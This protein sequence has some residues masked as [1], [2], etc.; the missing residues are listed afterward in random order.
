LVLSEKIFT[1]TNLKFNLK[2]T[3][4]R[5]ELLLPVALLAT[6]GVAAQAPVKDNL[7]L[8]AP[9]KGVIDVETVPYGSFGSKVFTGVTLGNAANAYSVAFGPAS[10]AWS[11]PTANAIL[12]THRA[13]PAI[14]PAAVNSGGVVLDF[15]TD[16]GTTWSVNQGPVHIPDGTTRF[17]G[18]YP[19]GVIFNPTGNTVGA[20]AYSATVAPTLSASNGSWGGT[21]LA[22]AKLNS[23]SMSVVSD[24]IQSFSIDSSFR[25]FRAGD[26]TFASGPQKVLA[27]HEYYDF[28]AT[29]PYNDTMWLA[30]GTWDA[31]NQ[32]VAYTW[33][34]VHFPVGLNPSSGV[35][36]IGT[37]GIAAN[38]NTVWIS[39]IGYNQTTTQCYSPMFAKS[40]DGGATFGSV[41]NVNLNTLTSPEVGGGTLLSY[42]QTIYSDWII[43]DLSTGFSQDLVVDKNGNPH[44]IVNICPAAFTTTP[45][46][47]A[48][49]AAFSIWSGINMI[50]DV[51]TDDG[52][53][54]WRAHLIDSALTFRG[55][56]GTVEEDNRPQISRNVA[57]DKVFC[58]YFSTDPLLYGSDNLYPDMHLGAVDVDGDSVLLKYN[59]T[60]GT[61]YEASATF[62]NVGHFAFDNG[63]GTFTIPT[64]VQ[65]LAGGDPAA[66]LSPTTFSYWP[67][68]YAPTDTTSSGIGLE[69]AANFGVSQSYPNPATTKAY[70]DIN[71]NDAANFSISVVNMLGQVVYAKDLGRLQAGSTRVEIPT[72][73]LGG[74]M[75]LYTITD[76]KGSVTNRMVVR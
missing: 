40:T 42:I 52:G 17:N 7:E 41:I 74:G 8:K 33:S 15:S 36:V 67:V 45:P 53:A 27:I 1:F 2:T 37:E 59:M 5:K 70:I 47:G 54:T 14:T 20:N 51:T 55:V 57:G 62:G 71:A 29:N 68:V 26:V 11:D 39:A 32:K 56:F 66:D 64:V 48:P 6:W 61:P 16:G 30:T 25:V 63:D 23:S 60:V 18:R 10:Y 22:T 49:G 34:K 76:G 4:M 46:G 58:S 19:Q 13:D 9:M 72:A 3:H 31:I 28:S 69:E 73:Q 21:A 38:G 35:S 50:V 43:S 65:N 12:F 44:M 75:Y 24:E